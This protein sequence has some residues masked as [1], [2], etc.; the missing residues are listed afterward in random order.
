[1]ARRLRLEYPGAIYHVMSRGNNKQR[2]FLDREDY[3]LF[4]SILKEVTVKFNWLC[5]VYCLMLTH[6]HLLIE[7]L[8][9]NL[10]RGMHYL[11]TI[12]AQS[13]NKKNNRV[14]HV[15]QGRYKAILVQKEKYLLVLSK[16]IAAN[17]VKDGLVEQP[18][19]WPWSSYRAT[20]GMEKEPEF[21]CTDWILGQFGE[22]RSG[23]IEA[24]KCFIN[25]TPCMEMPTKIVKG[26]IFLGDG[27]FIEEV[28]GKLDCTDK[29]KK[30]VRIQRMESR[31]ELFELF[32]DTATKLI[33]NENIL[34]AN[35]KYGYTVT[36]VSNFLG[37]H[38]STVSKAM[39][40]F[41]R[42]VG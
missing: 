12:F 2:V 4:L 17:P 7:T 31:P 24:Y 6:Y 21:L 30:V 34:L 20:I 3:E 38:H 29:I 19:D 11:N 14:G 42:K 5:H 15:F 8:E 10:S 9:A 32:H 41:H 1:M 33:R 16:Y 13:F 35:E 25:E 36:E 39:K 28:R 22:Y 37:V 18:E 23:A 26:D 40:K 27:D